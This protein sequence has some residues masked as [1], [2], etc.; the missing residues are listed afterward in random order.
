MEKCRNCGQAIDEFIG[1]TSGAI[2][3][4]HIIK[5]NM[6]VGLVWSSAEESEKHC[7]NPQPKT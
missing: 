3:W 7:R 6:E 2:A 4:S 5:V 1:K